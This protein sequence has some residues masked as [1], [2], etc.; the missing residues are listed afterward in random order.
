MERRDK[1]A[2]Q[3]KI[4]TKKADLPTEY[5]ELARRQA[6]LDQDAL[7]DAPDGLLVSSPASSMTRPARPK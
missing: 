5:E 6:E 3:Q 2:S 1:K 7:S 4:G